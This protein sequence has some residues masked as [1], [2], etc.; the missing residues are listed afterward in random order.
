M[1]LCIFSTVHSSESVLFCEGN[2]T[3]ILSFHTSILNVRTSA[4][5]DGALNYIINSVL[6]CNVEIITILCPCA[7]RSYSK[8]KKHLLAC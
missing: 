6:T 3:Q 5:S 2:V 7:I 1:Q 8:R 4:M